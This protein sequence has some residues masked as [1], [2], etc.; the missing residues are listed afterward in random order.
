MFRFWRFRIAGVHPKL[1]LNNPTW[2]IGGIVLKLTCA[3]K[4]R[5]WEDI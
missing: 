2:E 1:V 3:G 5:V 4:I